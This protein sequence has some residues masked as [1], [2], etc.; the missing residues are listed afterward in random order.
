MGDC[1]LDFT[2]A[3]C[4][5][6]DQITYLVSHVY[7]KVIASSIDVVNMQRPPGSTSG[8]TAPA[9]YLIA[10]QNGLPDF[11]PSTP[12][13]QPPPTSIVG[14]PWTNHP[15]FRAL[16]RAELPAP[17]SIARK[18]SKLASA[19]CA[20]K[21]DGCYLPRISARPRTMPNRAVARLER[22]PAHG[23]NCGEGTRSPSP[24]VAG[25]GTE[26]FRGVFLDLMIRSLKSR[27]TVATGVTLRTD[28]RL[29]L[30]SPPTEANF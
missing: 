5:E 10:A 30:T 15:I 24:P 27:T 13:T 4:T 9:A 22:F 12:V 8:D 25:G 11:L 16:M 18:G 21:H 6:R 7:D 2:V 19:L 3:R 26:A 1:S 14:V 28:L 23:A 20:G 17:S 29:C